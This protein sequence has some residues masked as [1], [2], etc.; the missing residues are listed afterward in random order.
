ML[1]DKSDCSNQ[2]S[3]DGKTA[4]SGVAWLLTD[5][6]TWSFVNKNLNLLWKFCAWENRDF[7]CYRIMITEWFQGSTLGIEELKNDE[8]WRWLQGG[9]TDEVLLDFDFS[10]VASLVE[11]YSFVVIDHILVG[12]F[13]LVYNT[14]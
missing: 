1:N 10:V 3:T 4:L 11:H 9:F 12:H 5:K 13:Q 2:V 14:C 7:F 8:D 6:L